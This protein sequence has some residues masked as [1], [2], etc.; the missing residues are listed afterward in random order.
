MSGTE[1]REGYR[2]FIYPEVVPPVKFS[3]RP[4]RRVVA[5]PLVTPEPTPRNRPCAVIVF[6]DEWEARRVPD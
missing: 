1:N 6:Q 3:R 2:V 5:E 4:T